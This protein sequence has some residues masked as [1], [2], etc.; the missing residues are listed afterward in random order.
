MYHS[1]AFDPAKD[2][3]PRTGL[4]GM[5]FGTLE[6]SS[7]R[8]RL[9]DDAGVSSPSGQTTEVYLSIQNPVRIEDQ[10]DWTVD[11]VYTQVR[12]QVEFTP[13]ERKS[14]EQAVLSG[15]NK[16]GFEALKSALNKHGTVRNRADVVAALQE[17]GLEVPRQGRDYLTAL[18]PTTGD[19]WRLKG[20]LYAHDFQ[21]ERLD[22]AVAETAGE[23][24]RGALRATRCIPS[25]PIRRWSPRARSGIV[26][27]TPGHPGPPPLPARLPTGSPGPAGLQPYR[28]RQSCACDQRHAESWQSPGAAPRTIRPV[29]ASSGPRAD[30]QNAI[31]LRRAGN[32]LPGDVD[33]ASG[34]ALEPVEIG[35][36]DLPVFGCPISRTREETT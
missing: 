17:A 7:D 8:R 23:R 31:D 16:A 3:V 24:T 30:Y 6:A 10:G 36:L 20:E 26:A 35:G 15:K 13:E 5:H 34:R 22:R 21:R 1:G 14:I 27:R 12:E 32:S 28:A 9:L 18:D 4:E 19:R 2:P 33:G 29:A 25:K 11:D